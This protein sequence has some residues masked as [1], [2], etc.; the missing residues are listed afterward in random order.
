MID[1]SAARSR[2]HGSATICQGGCT[3]RTIAVEPDWSPYRAAAAGI[4]TGLEV[5]EE[6]GPEPL[7]TI[8]LDTFDWRLW[9]AGGRLVVEHGAGGRLLRW[10]GPGPELPVAIPVAA[11][12]AGAAGLP[13]GYLRDR[14]AAVVAPRA[15]LA[16]GEL[17][18][19]RRR[20]RVVDGDG[21]I[22]LQLTVDRAE[23]LDG[24]GRPASE[25]R[26]ILEVTVMSGGDALADRLA[27]PAADEADDLLTLAAAVRGRCPGDYSSKLRLALAPDDRADDALR[28]I[29]AAL[30][31]TVEVNL[32]G[33]RRDLDPEFLHDLRV[34]V[35]RAR[36]ALSL[37][38][39]VLP[40]DAVGALAAELKW[41]GGFTGPLRD[42]DVAL[43]DLEQQ[44]QLLPPAWR[45]HLEPVA[46]Y[47]RSS[48][49]RARGRLVR[50][51]GSR[52]FEQLLVSWGRLAAPVADN[53]SAPPRAGDRVLDLADERI[54]RAWRKL[55][56][57][58][59]GCGD[60]PPPEILHRLRIDAKK[61]R[62]LLEFF[63]GLYPV[64]RVEPAIAGQKQ[65]Q[66][67]LGSFND[68][69]VQRRRLLDDARGLLAGGEPDAETLLAIGRLDALL[70]TRQERLRRKFRR[71]FDAFAERDLPA[72][73]TVGGEG[74]AT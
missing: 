8:F 13:A 44:R 58:G 38:D 41:V 29:L 21:S 61:L 71:R 28:T 2:S 57:R 46:G 33:T 10:S 6:A 66:D 50:A 11:V 69:S 22:L 55:L 20:W 43:L 16:V 51:L 48:R 64:E 1:S 32:D 19:R 5:V 47:L 26:G 34:A 40:A 59:R 42:L 18:I 72:A 67:L 63:R 27:P 3:I 52:R 62:Y 9:A 12:P 65:L 30:L 49:G 25:M 53:G 36:S 70:E 73:L 68:L 37:L 23:A 24:A 45:E 7:R 4:P 35:R 60:E 15:L 31:D 14:L 17:A 56:R 74:S 54:R 39:G